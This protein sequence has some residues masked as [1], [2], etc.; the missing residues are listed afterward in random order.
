MVVVGADDAPIAFLRRDAIDG[1]PGYQ[2]VV[3][4]DGRKVLDT[5]RNSDADLRI[6]DI[7]MPGLSGSDVFDQIQ[8]VPHLAKMPV[9]FPV[10][11][12]CP[13]VA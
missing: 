4:A 9:R 11:A 13:P 12:C 10:R 7:M 1:E 6:L 5:V 3:E 8:R 2:A